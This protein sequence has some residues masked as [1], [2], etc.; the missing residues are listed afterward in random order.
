MSPLRIAP[1]GDAALLVELAPRIDP[2]AN[3]RAAALGRALSSRRADL[4]DVV[5]AYASLTLYFDPLV[6]DAGSLEAHVRALEAG[7]PET[8]AAEGRLHE[9]P[10]S[11]GGA[12]GPD[13]PE[14]AAAAGMTEQQVIALH[15]DVT[16]RVYMLG[17]VPGFA[18]MA[19]VDSRIAVGR[20]AV[21]RPRVPPG[22][23]AVAA[24]QTGIYPVE[25]PGGW[26]LIGRTP[27]KPFDMERADPFLFRAGDRV[28]FHPVSGA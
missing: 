3:A 11:Y 12:D 21:P 26:H 13:L 22:S 18:Y 9:I 24:G 4:R 23:V 27:V 28:R 6:T 14:V 16:Y 20:R 1:A 19:P 2:A 25:T 15:A 5:V 8:A 17:F 10:V 7:L